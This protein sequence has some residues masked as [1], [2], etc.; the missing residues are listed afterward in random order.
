MQQSGNSFNNIHLEGR[1]INGRHKSAKLFVAVVGTHLLAY[2]LVWLTGTNQSLFYLLNHLLSFLPDIFWQIT[3]HF[4]ET[5]SAIAF[6][7]S[8]YVKNR[9]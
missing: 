7:Y 9:A 2:L 6:C 1:H 8:G 4:G 5:L 3:T